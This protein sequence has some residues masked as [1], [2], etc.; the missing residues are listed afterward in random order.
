MKKELPYFNIEECRGGCQSW[1]PDPVMKLGGCAAIAACETCIYLSLYKGTEELYP[2]NIKKLNK[3]DY[4]SFCMEMKPYLRPRIQGIDTLEL[5]MG[6]FRGYLDNSAVSCL[7]MEG[8]SG[9]LSE[10]H[11]ET[12]VRS[13]I[14]AGLPIPFLLLNHKNRKFKDFV[15]HWFMVAG[16]ED[17][18]N[19]FNIRT[20][21]YGKERYLPLS[22][23]WDT[24]YEK[25]GGMILYHLNENLS[26]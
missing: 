21:T 17:S 13:Q 18:D 2:F 12:A 3:K 20:I 5:F 10:R 6:G 19:G 7:T 23:L 15:W 1:F 8:F 11:A 22:E 4:L 24:E 14:D 16:Y 25:K 9:R 26:R